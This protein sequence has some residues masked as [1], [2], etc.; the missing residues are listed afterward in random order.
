MGQSLRLRRIE[1]HILDLVCWR[2][3]PGV[4]RLVGGFICDPEMQALVLVTI[5]TGS[6]VSKEGFSYRCGRNVG[7]LLPG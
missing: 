2:R 1:R 3:A 7:S 4:P 5:S 6:R